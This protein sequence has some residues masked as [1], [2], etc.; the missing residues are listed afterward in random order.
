MRKSQYRASRARVCGLLL[1]FAPIA[2]MGDTIKRVSGQDLPD[3]EIKDAKG[4]PVAG[5]LILQVL[6]AVVTS[7]NMTT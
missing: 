2:A 6:N 3:V 5:A 1:V 7:Q 4:K